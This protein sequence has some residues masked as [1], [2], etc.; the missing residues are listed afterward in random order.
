LHLVLHSP[1]GE[2][3]GGGVD[4]D[5]TYNLSTAAI[6]TVGLGI[7]GGVSTPDYVSFSMMEF[8]IS[9][10]Y[11]NADFGTN[12]LGVPL[13]AGNYLNAERAAFAA[14]GHPGLDVSFEHRGSNT[15]TGSF[16]IHDITYHQQA[17]TWVLDSFDAS[18][19]QNSEGGPLALTGRITYSSVPEPGSLLA[20]GAGLTLLSIRRRRKTA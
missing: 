16:T 15:L 14:S 12:M 8:P 9:T 10:H 5:V 17:S 18:F 20:I 1:P 19:S 7:R 3:I 2:W 13:T 4:N 6:F 11:M